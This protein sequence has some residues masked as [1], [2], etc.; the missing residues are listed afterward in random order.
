M[1]LEENLIAGD[2]GHPVRSTEEQLI[3]ECLAKALKYLT[4]EQRQVILLKFMDDRNIG[5]VAAIL[6]KN[7]R[8]VRSLQLRALAAL[9]RAME[10]ERCYEP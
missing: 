1:H 7:E 2:Y 4:E 3:R 5:E 8:A 6:G 10:R 9:H